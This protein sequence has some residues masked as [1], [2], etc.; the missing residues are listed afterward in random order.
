M[1]GEPVFTRTPDGQ[2]IVILSRADYDALCAS[3]G[4]AREA[5][6]VLQA[7]REGDEETLSFA[8]I[9]RLRAAATP[10]AFW[11]RK[12]GVTQAELAAA[13]GVPQSYISAIETGRKPGS[14]AL[15]RKIAD[16]LGITLNDLIPAE[17]V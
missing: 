12:R 2:E 17:T 8:E 10:L 5:R 15:L 4:D 14:P 7:L 6:A 3:S 16:H 13:T 1:S 11:R 9:E